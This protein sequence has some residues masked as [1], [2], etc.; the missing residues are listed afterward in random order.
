M[1]FTK[2]SLFNSNDFTKSK[3][4]IKELYAKEYYC[5][6][7][8]DAKAY[9]DIEKNS[10]KLIYRVNPKTLCHFG[11]IEINSSKNIDK[12]IAK[13]LLYFHKNELF[14]FENIKRSYK[15]IYA[16]DG[17]T[18]ASIETD[19]KES[20]NV[21]ISYT[22]SETQKPLHFKMGI[23]ASSDEGFMLEMG[24]KDR[25]FYGNLKTLTL[26]GRVTQLKQRVK[27]SYSM[28][29]F[30]RDMLGAEVGLENED[31]D[32]FSE[33]RLFSSLYLMQRNL[34]H[35]FKESVILERT[36]SYDSK[37]LALFTEKTLHI[38]SAMIE[39]SYDKRD[40]LLNPQNGYFL[41]AMLMGS[42]KGSIS[43]AT[44]SKV[45]FSAG[46]IYPFFSSILASKVSYGNIEKY[47]G[48][49]PS[50]YRF[51]GGGMSSN[52]AYL[53]RK[54]GPKNSDNDAIG[55]NS[56]IEST[57]EYR[58]AIAGNFRAVLFNDNSYIPQSKYEKKTIYNSGGVGLRY[59]S[60]IGPIAFDVGF[61][62]KEPRETS[63]FHF[64]IGESF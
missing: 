27:A 28:P 60:P 42:L 22:L 29:L 13:S 23:G 38:V 41:N 31:F 25:N 11:N 52:R 21:D 44:Y 58:F 36:S 32:A 53:Y 6:I 62:L 56:I 61:D 14:S 40:N 30:H 15:N 46:Y 20:G 12:K 48:E 7:A 3:K 4:D 9:I 54:M 19:I 1:P 63:A 55:F 49:I 39:W 45:K 24:L 51:Y 18:Q 5:N 35:N 59:V 47:A 10:A 34:P 43:D 17:V 33:Y 37:D 16:F 64:H 57:F 50:S 8:L 2:G 26:E